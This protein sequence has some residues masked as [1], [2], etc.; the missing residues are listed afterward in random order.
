MPAFRTTPRLL[1]TA[2]L[3]LALG[4]VSTIGAAIASAFLLR[5]DRAGGQVARDGD[6][7]QPWIITLEHPTA[8]RLIWFE[9]GRVYN[10]QGVGPPGASSVAVAGWSFATATRTNPRFR[11]APFDLPPHFRRAIE[12]RGL[13]WGLAEDRRGWPFPAFS[14]LISAPLATDAP[15]IFAYQ[16]GVPLPSKDPTFRESLASARVVPLTP[17]WPGLGADAAAHAAIWWSILTLAGFAFAG[18]RR[19]TRR[20]R[21]QCPQ[22]GYDVNGDFE[23]GCSECGWNR[24]AT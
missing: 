6:H 16:R 5:I 1:P 10:K 7:L 2:L 4:A 14:C 21:G 20:A 22:C 24:S 8:S 19:A 13:V 11:H 17:L 3:S 9:K 12:T 15:A 23:A 18:S